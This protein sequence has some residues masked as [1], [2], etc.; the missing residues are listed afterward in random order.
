[1]QGLRVITD[2]VCHVSVRGE[3]ELHGQ[4]VQLQVLVSAALLVVLR[5]VL[6]KTL[7]MCNVQ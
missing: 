1:M 6:Y 7:E 5:V 3:K 2:W 4:V